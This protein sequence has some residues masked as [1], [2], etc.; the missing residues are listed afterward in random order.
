MWDACI[1]K[2]EHVMEKRIESPSQEVKVKQPYVRPELRKQGR[3][4]EMTQHNLDG[5]SQKLNY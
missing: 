3:I 4:E 5:F 2:K 1:A